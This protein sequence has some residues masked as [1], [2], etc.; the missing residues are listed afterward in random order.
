MN[1]EKM[2]RNVTL[3][4]TVTNLLLAACKVI[5][6]V[7][8]GSIAIT[9]DGINNLTD[10]GSVI[11]TW[12]GYSIS[13]KPADRE[14]PYGHG[15][16]EYISSQIISFIII[17]VGISLLS[18]SVQR[19]SADNAV[20]YESAALWI[21]LISIAAKLALALYY[22]KQYAATGMAS[23]KATGMDALTDSLSSAVTLF[24]FFF[25]SSRIPAD[26]ICGIIVSLFI[27]YNGVSIFR[28]V[29]SVLLGEK[30]DTVSARKIADIIRESEY[31]KNPH[32]IRI[33]YYG[34]RDVY[35]SGDVEIDGS[36]SVARAHEIIDEM[37]DRI[38]QKTGIIFTI[39]ADPQIDEGLLKPLQQKL[40]Q[41]KEE[42]KIKGFHDLHLESDGKTVTVDV[43]VSYDCTDTSDIMRQ[44]DNSTDSARRLNVRFDRH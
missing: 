31:L 6:G 33:H 12:I 14:H 38:L 44:L 3:I 10:I 43:I 34:T 15:R 29:S 20:E 32:D 35:G 39:H 26:A 40:T 42:G 1:N 2:I 27:I 30:N 18:E 5:A 36:M 25:A 16:A 19:L 24:G 22:R 41:L 13:E 17:S 7:M 8:S 37:E 28:E 21:I 4:G 11:V 23:L 9:S